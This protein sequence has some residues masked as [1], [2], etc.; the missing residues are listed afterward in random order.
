LEFLL[1]KQRVKEI[2]FYEWQGWWWHQWR[3]DDGWCQLDGR[4]S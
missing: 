4:E 3:S 1:K 2:F